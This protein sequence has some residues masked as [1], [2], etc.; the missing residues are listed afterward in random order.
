MGYT[1]FQNPKW[2][3]LFTGFLIPYCFGDE[4]LLHLTTEQFAKKLRIVIDGY[5][6]L[7]SY[8]VCVYV[9]IYIYL[10]FKIGTY[11]HAYMYRIPT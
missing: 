6:H 10:L 5:F 9:Y 8:Y 1:R 4:G 3:W 7:F 2:G 11:I